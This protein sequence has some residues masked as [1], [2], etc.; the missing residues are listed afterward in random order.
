MVD[1]SLLK[2][3]LSRFNKYAFQSFTLELLRAEYGSRGIIPVTRFGEGIYKR[4]VTDEI[5]AAELG[6]VP[7]SE[8]VPRQGR[9]MYH[10]LY[11][12]HFLP[13]ELLKHPDHVDVA[14]P[15]ML[16]TLE[17]IYQAYKNKVVLPMPGLA[18]PLQGIFFLNNIS[19]F[20][21]RDYGETLLHK[22]REIAAFIGFRFP[23]VFVGNFDS[24]IER[25]PAATEKT[26]KKFLKRHKEG[27]CIT[28]TAGGV[29]IND[30]TSEKPLA[31]GV[32][33]QSLDPYEPLF[34]Q[35]ATRAR[36]ILKEFESLINS[37]AKESQLEEFLSEH[38]KD[39][40]GSKYDRIETQV[41]LRFPDL[42]LS[43]KDRRLDIFLR[44]SVT[45]DWE[46][47][48]VKRAVE[49]TGT[50]RDTTVIKQEVLYAMQQVK[51]YARIL[52][53]DVVKKRLA[54]E[55]LEFY[56]PSLNLIIGRRPQL[57]PE[58][59]RHL[60]M[61]NAKDVKLITYDDLIKEMQLRFEDRYRFIH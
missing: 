54:S 58:Q 39:V 33:R 48:E 25:Q 53:Q 51:N 49:I 32:G 21:T 35:A 27:I 34:T 18:S 13:C 29:Q 5:L 46:L 55:G 60:V 23:D 52:S 10:G 8:R 12:C 43:G 36:S 57:P 22:Y 31:A 42:D 19:G 44:N 59:W 6:G 45:A 38:Y 50:Y 20:S 1:E 41:W 30:F 14:D 2:N 47:F 9:G 11:V 15:L 17:R 56:E 4:D 7:G 3:L 28:L 40:F 61:H 16:R 37:D 24:F 26:L